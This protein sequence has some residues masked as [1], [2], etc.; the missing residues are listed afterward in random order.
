MCMSPHEM[1]SSRIERDLDTIRKGV[2]EGRLREG[3]W[4]WRVQNLEKILKERADNGTY[5][6]AGKHS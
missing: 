3:F 6:T 5:G 2:A 1:K 4:K